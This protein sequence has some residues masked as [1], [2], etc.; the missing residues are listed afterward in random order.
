MP[1]YQEK[2]CPSGDTPVDRIR[3]IVANVIDVVTTQGSKAI[4][5]LGLRSPTKY[6]SPDVDVIETE[7]QVVV[8][9]DLPGI[10][11]G[12]VEVQLVGNMLTIKGERS[13]PDSGPGKTVH[14]RERVSGPFTRSIPLP[15][16]VNP[17]LVSAESQQGVLTVRLTKEDRLKSRQIPITVH[18]P[19]AT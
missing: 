8:S 1:T 15:V 19:P 17:E 6:W 10:D 2:P 16:A 4:D 9:V 11:P 7:E 3:D 13:L 14:R 5:N 18:T 12:R